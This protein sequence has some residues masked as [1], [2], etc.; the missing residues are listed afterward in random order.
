MTD[1]SMRTYL[2]IRVM[3]STG[4]DW[5]A[6]QEAVASTAIEHPEWDL[7]ERKSWPDWVEY[8]AEHGVLS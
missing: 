6:A 4:C 1:F 3:E 7:D 2:A 5:F 8:E